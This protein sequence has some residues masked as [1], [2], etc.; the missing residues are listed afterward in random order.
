MYSYM[1]RNK[2]PSN[3]IIASAKDSRLNEPAVL[4]LE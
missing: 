3:T 2:N 4:N 1:L